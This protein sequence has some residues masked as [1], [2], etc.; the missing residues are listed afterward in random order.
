M[1]RSATHK[2]LSEE[3]KEAHLRASQETTDARQRTE[4]VQC[5]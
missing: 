1:Q 4:Q 5:K 3:E 2:L